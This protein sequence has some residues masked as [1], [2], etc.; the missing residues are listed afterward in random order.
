MLGNRS[1]LRKADL[2]LGDLTTDGGFLQPAQAK[3]FIEIA[4]RKQKLSGMI[5]VS[6]IASPTALMEKVRFNDQVLQPG[7]SGEALAVAQRSKP[8]LSK[9]Q[10]DAQLFKAEVRIPTEVLEDNIEN[11]GLKNTLMR[12]A[13]VAVG[14]DA[15]KVAIQGDTASAVPLLAVLDG[16]LK[17][18]TTN[19]VNAAGARLDKPICRQMKRAMPKEFIDDKANMRYLTSINAEDD[20]AEAYSPRATKLGDDVNITDWK[21]VYK[22]IPVEPIPMFPETL[23]TGNDTNALFG[24]PKNLNVGMWRKIKVKTREDIEADVFVIVISL[25]F[26]AKYVEETAVVKA[27]TILNS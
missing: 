18:A 21:S 2:A 8:N 1:L 17:L 27:T 7:V 6:P 23:G 12:L 13:S 4:T 9:V 11:G 10:W 22:A 5:T 24:H 25:R 16:F 15:E 3:K 26:D 14:R 20:Y 19:V